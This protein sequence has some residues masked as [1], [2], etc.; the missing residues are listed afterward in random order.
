M[1]KGIPN[2][3]E[4]GNGMNLVALIPARGGSTRLPRKNIML[5]NKQPLI[6]WIC[7][8]VQDSNI[9]IGYVSTEDAEIKSTVDGFG[10]SKIKTI[11]RALSTTTDTATAIDVI[12]DFSSRVDWSALVLLQAPCPLLKPEHSHGALA[13]WSVSKY[14]SIVSV[15]RQLRFLWDRE[16]DPKYDIRNRPRTQDYP[17]LLIECGAM[18]MVKRDAYK[19][20][21]N[22]LGGNIAIYELPD[23]MYN[24]IDTEQDL[25][26]VEALMS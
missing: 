12:D 14:N 23:Y 2:E 26:I 19:Q 1:R 17:G 21:H 13:A 8:S 11:D 25:K 7:K 18:Y 10:F 3:I 6:Y 24:E 22:F 16:G 5:L 15:V 9:P 4:K 20:Y